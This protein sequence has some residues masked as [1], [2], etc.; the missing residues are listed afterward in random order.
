LRP[1]GGPWG[2]TLQRYTNDKLIPAGGLHPPAERA[3]RFDLLDVRIGTNPAAPPKACA[4]AAT[5]TC[6]RSAGSDIADYGNNTGYCPYGVKTCAITGHP[7]GLGLHAADG[8]ALI[9]GS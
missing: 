9:S 1:A 8:A 2:R 3:N 5:I 7:F 4:G 6:V